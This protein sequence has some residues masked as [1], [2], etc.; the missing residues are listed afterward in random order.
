[1]RGWESAK[2]AMERGATFYREGTYSFENVAK[3]ETQD[4]HISLRW[5]ITIKLDG[6]SEISTASLRVTSVFRKEEGAWRVV[7]RQADPL[8][9]VQTFES[10]LQRFE[11]Q[12]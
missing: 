8:T 1:M 4:S 5:S 11:N 2:K 12:R 3:I 6:K 7:H 10:V 9:S